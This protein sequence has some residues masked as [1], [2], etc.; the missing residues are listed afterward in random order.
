MAM[1]KTRRSTGSS[2]NAAAAE[3][4]YRGASLFLAEQLA[5]LRVDEMHAGAGRAGDLPV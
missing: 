4:F 2:Q 3:M 5:G 1:A